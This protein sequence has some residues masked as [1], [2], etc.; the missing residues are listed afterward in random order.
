MMNN[1]LKAVA[2][3][4]V[5]TIVQEEGRSLEFQ[6]KKCQ[7]FCELK[8]YDLIEVIED[9]ESGGNDKEK[10]FYCCWIK[11]KIKNLMSLLYMKAQEFQE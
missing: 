8:G 3:C 11:L 7:D 2:Y 6:V 1:N 9:V 4:R 10:D 5:S